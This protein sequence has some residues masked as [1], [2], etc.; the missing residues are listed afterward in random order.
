MPGVLMIEAMQVAGVLGFISKMS[1]QE[2]VIFICSGS[3][4]CV[5][6]RQVIPVI[7]SFYAPKKTMERHSIYKFGCTAWAMSWQP[8]QKSPLQSSVP[9]I[10]SHDF[11]IIL[12]DLNKARLE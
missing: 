3:I 8:V 10:T 12:H 7:S 4:K 2:M 1:N 11:N 6:K 5:F 9:N